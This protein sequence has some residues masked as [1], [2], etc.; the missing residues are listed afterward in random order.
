MQEYVFLGPGVVVWIDQTLGLRSSDKTYRG[1]EGHFRTH[2][3]DE[4]VVTLGSQ[5]RLCPEIV[6]C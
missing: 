5:Q 4:E 3:Q 6:Y 1:N 2:I